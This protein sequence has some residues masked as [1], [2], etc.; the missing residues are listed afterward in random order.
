[1]P[2]C[3]FLLVKEDGVMQYQY[4]IL[5][6]GYSMAEYADEKDFWAGYG[7]AMDYADNF[8]QAFQKLSRSNYICVVVRTDVISADHLS[9]LRGNGKIPILILPSNYNAAQRYACVRA[10]IMQYLHAAKPALDIPSQ[11][12]LQRYLHIPFVQ[13]QGLTVVSVKDLS[14]CLEYRSVEVRG[15]KIDLTVKE[16]DILA[17][18]IMN[19]KRVFTYEMI[20]EIVWREDPEY[21]S[22]TAIHNHI[23]RLNKK[24][25]IAPDIPDYITSIRGI[26]YKFEI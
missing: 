19:P 20:I 15:Q 23:S 6:I 14:F 4:H 13:L 5:G 3:P 11:D 8:E 10:S 12:S 7:I 18:L 1:L 16:F 2:D 21:Y 9:A 25:K 17:L 24:L 26:G 22:R